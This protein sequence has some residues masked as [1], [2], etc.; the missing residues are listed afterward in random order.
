MIKIIKSGLINKQKKKFNMTRLVEE[1][2][3]NIK[4]KLMEQCEGTK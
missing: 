4:T 1:F 2:K 3:S